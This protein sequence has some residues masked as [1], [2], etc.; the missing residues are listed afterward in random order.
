MPTKNKVLF[1]QVLGNIRN[2]LSTFIRQYEYV[3]NKVG[4]TVPDQDLS[5]WI[6]DTFVDKCYQIRANIHLLFK[7]LGKDG[8]P[9]NI[10]NA[11]NQFVKASHSLA[12]LREV[13]PFGI[14]RYL[15]AIQESAR[16]VVDEIE[17]SFS[18]TRMNLWSDEWKSTRNIKPIHFISSERKRYI[19]AREELVQA[20]ANANDSPEHVLNH[21]RTAIDLAIKERF[22]FK[23]IPKM[24][25]FIEQA[26]KHNFP[27]PSYD[28]IY[29]Y[30]SEGSQRIHEGKIHTSFE[31]NEVIRTVSNFIDE[32]DLIEVTKGEIT[33]F[34]RKCK[35]AQI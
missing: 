6:M 18:E 26:N 31:A 11:I 27:L 7:E 24:V 5:H 34:V 4:E 12:F 8:T 32:L 16:K 15:S 2:D 13:P 29:T 28:L 21:L 23:K 10:D 1:E 14:Q 9:V 22:G 30:F 25:V 17:W 33:D 3:A 35:C 19:K 20:K